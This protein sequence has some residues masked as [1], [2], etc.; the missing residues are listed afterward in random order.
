MSETEIEL[1][2]EQAG[3]WVTVFRLC[4]RLG[5]ETNVTGKSGLALVTAFIQRGA[6]Q[7]T[8]LPAADGRTVW[9]FCAGFVIGLLA[10][11]AV[12]GGR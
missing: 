4:E 11:L 10:C 8:A 3:A 9:A 1:W 2:Q 12:I 5:M 7:R 6:A